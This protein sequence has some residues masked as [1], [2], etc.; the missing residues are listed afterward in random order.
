MPRNN[1]KIEPGHL[2]KTLRIDMGQ[3]RTQH[4]RERFLQREEKILTDE[5]N[6]PSASPWVLSGPALKHVT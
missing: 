3:A 5:F 2:S 1:H 4:T 6:F